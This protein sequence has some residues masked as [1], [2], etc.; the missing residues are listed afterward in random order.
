MSANA[1]KRSRVI[2]A[3]LGL[4]AVSGMAASSAASARDNVSFSLSIGT[5]A[6]MQAPTVVY[7]APPPVYYVPSTTY[8][9]APIVTYDRPVRYV[10]EHDHG[11]GHAYGWRHDDRHG[12][13]HPGRG[14]GHD[15]HG[16]R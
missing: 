1:V 2:K 9:A 8:Y 14:Y 15:R 12:G 13:H 7:H 6:Y 3:I 4:I 5:P 16:R 10:V 11:R